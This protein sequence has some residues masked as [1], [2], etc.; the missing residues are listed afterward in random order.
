MDINKIPELEDLIQM[1]SDDY[2]KLFDD[3]AQVV[4]LPTLADDKVVNTPA[5]HTGFPTFDSAMRGGMRGGD[6]IVVSGISGMGK[7]SFVQSIIYNL[8]KQGVSTVLFSYEVTPARL[9]EKFLMMGMEKDYIG[10]YAPKKNES[11]DVTWIKERIIEAKKRYDTHVVA[12]DHLGFL[13]PSEVKTSDNQMIQL[14]KI[15]RELKQLAL[16]LDMVIIL[17]AHVKKVER[18]TEPTMND[19]ASSSGIFQEADQVFMVHRLTVDQHNGK[20]T[21]T[22]SQHATSNWNDED[23]YSSFNSIRLLKNRLTGETKKIKA[24]LRDQRFIQC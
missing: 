1:T 10:I 17:I 19:I 21:K 8:T 24:E 7:T 11:G 6:L 22:F 23:I 16:E 3:P 12:I 4:P 14:Q 13:S 2:I 20:S 15:A 9:H 5:F 18:E